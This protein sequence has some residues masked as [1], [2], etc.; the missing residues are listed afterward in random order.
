MWQIGISFLLNYSFHLASNCQLRLLRNF[1][2]VQTQAQA[3]QKNLF[4]EKIERDCY[5]NN[6]K[7]R[8]LL[9]CVT[10]YA[11]LVV[12]RARTKVWCFTRQL[13]SGVSP[14][15]K[16]IFNSFKCQE[17]ARKSKVKVTLCHSRLAFRFRSPL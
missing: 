7:T 5:K 12:S 3:T 10:W 4:E 8:R 6:K 15:N 13:R 9:A 1:S 11:I 2:F 14:D 16:I 17:I